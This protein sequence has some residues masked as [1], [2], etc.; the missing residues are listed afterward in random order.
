VLTL[1]EALTLI[2]KISQ[3]GRAVFESKLA[4]ILGN[5]I[6]SSSFTKKIRA[7]CSY[8]LL[9]EQP[10]GQF[11]LTEL[12]LA[13]VLPRST[14]EE[15][16]AKKQAFL[17]IEAHELIFRQH[18]GK[19]LPADE[20]LRNILEQDGEMPR[21]YSHEWVKSF[22]EGARVAGL[23]YNRGDGKVQISDSP[24]SDASATEARID[25][26]EVDQET[27]R[28]DA[29]ANQSLAATRR[30]EPQQQQTTHITESGH[31]TRIDLSGGRRAEISIPDRLSARDA[32]KLQKA[33]DGIKV[34]IESMVLE[35]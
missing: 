11:G 8:G 2:G 1:P 29:H 31:V 3:E 6:S 12:A 10:D 28:R 34:I 25:L 23:L 15:A 32:Q 22:K 30:I 19:L 35:D 9:S 13:I 5:T 7:L 16:E 33:L 21:E 14:Q 27:E 4:A 24:L 17:K 20:F 18:K 26:S